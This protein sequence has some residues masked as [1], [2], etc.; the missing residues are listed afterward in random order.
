MKKRITTLLVWVLAVCMLSGCCISHTW[1]NATCVTP[2]TC[3]KCGQTDGAAIGH[4]WQ[5]ATCTLDQ[6]CSICG[7]IGGK[8]LGHKWVAATC[9]EPQFCE[10][11]GVTEGRALDHEWSEATDT[12][13]RQCQNCKTMEPL[14]TPASGE[15]FVGKGKSCKSSLTI[16]SS[17]TSSCYIKLKDASGNDVYSFFVRAGETVKAPVPGGN[18]YVYFAYGT[19]WY[20]PEYVFGPETT[21]AKDDE[22]SD[23]N[24][25]AWEYTLYPSTGG[26][27][28]E[29]PI[30]ADEF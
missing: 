29:T 18:F 11:C 5:D 4:S 6:R 10:E 1:E 16:R 30:D 26:N 17:T 20:G 21:Y 13:P 25:Y 2:K 22:L 14:P 28:S 12:T 8:A 27:F 23:F 3:A 9:Y 19:D 24:T 7:E 15:V